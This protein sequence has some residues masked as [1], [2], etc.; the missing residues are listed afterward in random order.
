MYVAGT[1]CPPVTHEQEAG[2]EVELELVHIWDEFV[3]IAAPNAYPG[4]EFL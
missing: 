4:V 1:C 3:L 2:S